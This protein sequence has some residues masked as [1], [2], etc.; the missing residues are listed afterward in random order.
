MLTQPRKPWGRAEPRHLG[1]EVEEGG[2]ETEGGRSLVALG[3]QSPQLQHTRWLM[4]PL[5]ASQL[6]LVNP[7]GPALLQTGPAHLVS[8]VLSGPARKGNRVQVPPRKS[9]SAERTSLALE[10]QRWEEGVERSF[11]FPS[12]Q[13]Q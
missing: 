3:A 10:N 9:C 5:V 2:S 12:L 8:R 7:L 4:S 11:S 1:R 13:G 6:H